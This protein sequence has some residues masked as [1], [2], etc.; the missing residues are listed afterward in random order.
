M[1]VQDEKKPPMVGGRVHVAEVRS[2]HQ[3][4]GRLLAAREELLNAMFM[5]RQRGYPS[6]GQVIEDHVNGPLQGLLE[7]VLPLLEHTERPEDYEARVRL[8]RGGSVSGGT[9]P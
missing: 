2:R 4:V 7:Q 9:Q 8:E 3:V 6:A 5:A 1:S